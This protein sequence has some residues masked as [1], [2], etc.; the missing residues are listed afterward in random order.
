MFLPNAFVQVVRVYGIVYASHLNTCMDT[1]M[2]PFSKFQLIS[3]F[4]FVV[5][6]PEDVRLTT[7]T[8][9]KQECTG[10]VINF[11]CTAEAN[12]AVQTYLLYENDTVI[13]NMGIS[14]TWIKTMENSGQF[15]FRCEANNSIQG[16]ETSD[17]TVLTFEGKVHLILRNYTAF[18]PRLRIKNISWF[19]LK[20]LSWKLMTR[21]L[22]AFHRNVMPLN[23]SLLYV[24]NFTCHKRIIYWS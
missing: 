7:N 19:A 14:G 9:R 3:L 4:D 5:D 22:D 1:R 18:I 24:P 12:P 8:T 17:D 16:I 21:K 23:P 20:I 6:K 10:V 15:V 13:E 11:T 2:S